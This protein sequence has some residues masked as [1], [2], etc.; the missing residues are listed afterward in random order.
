MLRKCHSRSTRTVSLS[1]I[2]LETQ[3]M[4]SE[5]PSAQ[6]QKVLVVYYSL[7]GNTARVARD[8]AARTG[9]DLESLRDP[10][11][12]TGF[13][14]FMKASLDALRGHVP[15]V[16]PLTRDIA[17]YDLTI[18][19]TPVWARRM[20]PAIRAYLQ[21]VRGKLRRVAFFVTSG[22]TDVVFLLPALEKAAGT[23]AVAT[24]GFN[25]RELKDPDVYGAKLTAFQTALG[26]PLPANGHRAG[27]GAKAA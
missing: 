18:I 4:G 20:T 1:S 26:L 19:G 14:G 10:S 15:K 21:I 24:A 25:Q 23:R 7:T 17:G 9:A 3:D 5:T 22:D 27:E 6:A 8:I 13:F 16:G 12:G 11:H 2:L